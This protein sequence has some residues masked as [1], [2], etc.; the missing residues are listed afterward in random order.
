MTSR[1]VRR[2]QTL[3]RKAGFIAQ[4]TRGDLPDRDVDDIGDQ[5]LSFAEVKALATGDPLILEKAAVD[6]DVARLTRLERAHHDDQHRLRRTFETATSRAEGAEQRA[7]TLTEAIG[8]LVD[9]RGDRFAMK[10]DGRTHTKRADAGLHL[11]QLLSDR[12]EASPPETNGPSVKVG[13]LG[14]LDVHAQ[15]ITTVEDE[16]RMTIP[17][18]QVELTYAAHEWRAADPT[19]IVGRLE[20]HLQRLPETLAATK[21]DAEAARSEASR[22]DARIGQ[23]GTAARNLPADDGDSRRSTNSWLP[24][25]SHRRTS[26]RRLPRPC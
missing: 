20:R 3:E 11:Q 26:K 7:A 14:G 10:V 6:A 2:R 13:T 5:A 19:M 9:T 12:L 22:A 1:Q 23:P 21:A 4:V 8:R 24:P 15:A 25:P 18:A 17:D 16:V